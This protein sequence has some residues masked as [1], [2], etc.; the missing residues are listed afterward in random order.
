MINLVNQ[1][2]NKSIKLKTRGKA[3]RV[4][5]PA[6]TCLQNSGINGPKYIKFLSDVDES[7]TVLT[8]SSHPLWN[9]SAQNEGGYANFQRFRC[10][11]RCSAVIWN[12]LPTYLQVSSLSA[13]AFA[14]HLKAWNFYI[15][16][17]LIVK[18]SSA[19]AIWART[20]ALSSTDA[21]GTR[22]LAIVSVS[23]IPFFARCVVDMATG[24]RWYSLHRTDGRVELIWLTGYIQRCL[25]AEDQ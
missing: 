24:S 2:I 20:T 15:Y 6:Q 14:R 21:D 17:S 10:L 18:W 11:Q 7:L 5:R 13:A 12:S 8:R 19:W 25:L 9:A 3:Q 1:S 23:V 16:F 4:A 22:M